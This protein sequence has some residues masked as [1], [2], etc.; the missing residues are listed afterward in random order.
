VTVD[1]FDVS[2]DIDGRP[3]R[4]GT[5]YITRRGQALSTSFQYDRGYL[6][7]PA[8]YSL[9]PALPHYLGQHATNGLPGAFADTAPDRWGRNLIAKRIR[10]AER[11]T[12]RTPRRIDDVDYLLGVSDLTRQGALRFALSGSDGWLEPAAEVPK[13]IELPRLLHAADAVVANSEDLAAIKVLLDAGTGTLGGARPK[14]SVRDN[15]GRLHIAKFP[16]AG[17]DW[18]VMGWEKTALDIADAAG[19]DTPARRL[20][21]V[22]GRSVLLLARFDRVDG[23]R[24][25]Y[26]SAMTL[27]QR[28]DGNDAD[29]VELAESFAEHAAHP[30]ADLAQLWRR[31]AFSVAIHNTDDHLRN[32][33]F[34]RDG[35]GWRLSPIFDVNPNPDTGEQRVTSIG[36]A[37]RREEELEGLMTNAAFFGLDQRAARQTLAEV[38]AATE[39]WRDMANR[40]GVAEAQLHRFADAFDGLRADAAGYLGSATASSRRARKAVS[41]AA[42]GATARPAQR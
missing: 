19:I 18:D 13:L 27:M 10:A 17:D 7:N 15:D 1:A 6:A 22:A 24:I 11:S 31:I 39:N 28:S 23:R 40:N 2:V 12:E 29:Y 14:A 9:D 33:G 35:P 3:V 26:L 38:F 16:K 8:G 36:G 30:A 20:T 32:H 42:D 34:L 5:A 37:Y 21:R 4:A 25:G 41:K